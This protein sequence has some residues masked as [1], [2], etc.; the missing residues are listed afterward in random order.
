MSAARGFL[1][2]CIVFVGVGQSLAQ[3]LTPIDV[4]GSTETRVAGISPSGQSVGAYISAGIQHGFLLSGGALSTIDFP[5]ATSTAATAINGSGQ[6]VGV[7]TSDGVQDGY[8]L[9][10]GTFSTIH[11]PGATV[12]QVSGINN[13]GAITGLYFNG[14]GPGHGFLLQ[15]GTFT[16]I[17][18]PGSVSTLPS[19]INNA[20][21]IVGFYNFRGVDW[22]F[23]LRDGTYTTIMFPGAVGTKLH[24]INNL[25][26]IT[27]FYIGTDGFAHGLLYS[28]G[29]FSTINFSGASDTYISGVNDIGEFDGS[30][31]FS[32]QP[33]YAFSGAPLHGFF[34][35][36]MSVTVTFTPGTM[37][38]QVAVFN[39]PPSD[40]G[41]HS[42]KIT[43]SQTLMAHTF[44]V[45]PFY[46]P[47][48][49]PGIGIGDGICETGANETN[50]FD[51]RFTRFFLGPPVT[52]G[53]LVPQIYP[54]SNNQGVFYRVSGAPAFG[55]GFY[56][57]DIYLYVAWN[58]TLL[59]T[60]PFASDYQTTPRLYDDPSDDTV[61]GGYP[62]IPGFP[63]SPE[64]HQFVFDVTTYFSAG[65]GQVGVDPG[66]GAR[67]RQYSDFVVAFPLTN[68]ALGLPSYEYTWSKP[69]H[70]HSFNQ[71]AA[72][73]HA[74][75]NKNDD[76]NDDNNDNNDDDILRLRFTLTPDTPAG[77]AATAPQQVG[78]AI[79][80]GDCAT[81]PTPAAVQ[82]IQVPA[83]SPQTVTYN[84][85]RGAYEFKMLTAFPS[86]QYSARVSSDLFP[87]QC[88]NFRIKH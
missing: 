77:I 36:G 73:D 15:G 72:N 42:I 29:S 6:I 23:V 18:V 68:S 59:P 45:T 86:G 25:G 65:G 21:D 13:N 10:E 28:D 51:C 11:F 3:N 54:Y 64:D 14:S 47:T 22:G 37:Q 35:T 40:P 32:T 41:A 67:I 69:K 48:S 58:P 63:Y 55:S 85:H 17:D 33:Y 70:N 43:E 26:Q 8:L 61:Q 57:G 7:H 60:G 49:P 1:V 78:V 66:L 27:G 53:N 20:G 31:D 39:G 80:S 44:T 56:S 12:T 30:Y 75:D 71:A 19:G 52:G 16:L 83:G 24:S 34:G 62:V 74:D 46:V 50:D 2:A 88:T 79:L 9:S 5:G 38:S 81:T 4:P 84:P 87:D 76:S 82:A